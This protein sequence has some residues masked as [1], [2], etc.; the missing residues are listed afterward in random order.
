MPPRKRARRSAGTMVVY[1]PKKRARA[2]GAIVPGYTRTSGF[3]GRFSGGRKGST[4]ELKFLDV[5][6]DDASIASAGTIVKDTVNVIVQGNTESNR[7][8]RKVVIKKIGWRYNI[9]GA[10]VSSTSASKSE[11][12]R[13]ILY[14]DKQCNGAAATAL[15]ILETD[16]YQ[17]FNQLANTSRFRILM[18]RTHTLDPK[19]GAGDGTANDQAGYGMT[20][21]FYKNCN[22]PIEYDNSAT[23]GVLTTIRSNNLGVLILGKEGTILSMLGNMRLRF[24]DA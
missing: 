14:L 21:S 24:T 10:V 23:T 1:R 15:D 9:S 18:D 8:G 22:I 16:D 13:L 12:V 3:Y 4:Q 6:I 7:I 11:T 17:S 2:R 19:A 5:D 20:G